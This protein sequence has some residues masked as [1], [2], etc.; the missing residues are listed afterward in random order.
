M[1]VDI[2]TMKTRKLAKTAGMTQRFFNTVNVFWLLKKI[3]F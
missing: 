1:T 2:L 3:H